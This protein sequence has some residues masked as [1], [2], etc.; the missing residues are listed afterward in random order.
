MHDDGKLQIHMKQMSNAR[1]TPISEFQ[2][3]L[4][5]EQAKITKP[6]STPIAKISRKIKL[7]QEVS[8]YDN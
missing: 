2:R 6:K 1:K 7:Y 8:R 5:L 3:Q 4:E